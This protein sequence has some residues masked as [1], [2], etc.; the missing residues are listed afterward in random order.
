MDEAKKAVARLNDDFA[1]VEYLQTSRRQVYYTA[2]WSDPCGIVIPIKILIDLEPAAKHAEF[3]KTLG[4][5]K[6]ARDAS[7]RKWARAID[8]MRYD[9]QAAMNLDVFNAAT[10]EKRN[11]FRHVIQENI[12]P[13][14][15]ATKALHRPGNSSSAG[16]RVTRPRWNT[17]RTASRRTTGRIT[18]GGLIR[19]ST[20]GLSSSRRLTW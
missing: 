6:T 2:E 7:L 4:D 19:T 9:M 10:G 5:F 17:T 18:I 3:G 8:D 14:P 16:G 13:Y 20:A 11:D 12:H 1:I 15:N